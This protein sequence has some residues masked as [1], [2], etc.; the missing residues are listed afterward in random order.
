MGA[1]LLA[2][3]ERAG[4]RFLALAPAGARLVTDA[5][6]LADEPAVGTLLVG[7]LATREDPPLPADAVYFA[8]VLPALDVLA[9]IRIDQLDPEFDVAAAF[10]AHDGSLRRPSGRDGGDARRVPALAH[11]L[12]AV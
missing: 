1:W 3:T 10:D 5:G 2:E 11:R 7:Q 6:A 12:A 8:G 4:H 9:G